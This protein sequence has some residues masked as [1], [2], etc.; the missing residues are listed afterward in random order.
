MMIR[1]GALVQEGIHTF[2]YKVWNPEEGQTN[3]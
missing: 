1:G 3:A 2:A